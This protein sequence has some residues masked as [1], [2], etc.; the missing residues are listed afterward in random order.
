M[1]KAKKK[2]PKPTAKPFLVRPGARFT[3]FNDGLCCTDIHA[4]GPITR[5][6]ARDMRRIDPQS[7]ELNEELEELCLKPVDGHCYFQRDGLC[8]VHAE[9]GAAAKPAGCRRF[10]YGLLKTPVGGRIT[11]EHRCPCRTLGERPEID[12]VDAEASLKDRS[13]ILED[14]GEI[15]AKVDLAPHR[16]VSFEEYVEL[17]TELI[18]RLLAGERAEDVLGTDPLCELDEGSWSVYAAE[19]FDMR[20]GTA[21]GE[22]LVMFGDALLELSAGH[23]PPE[24]LRPWAGAFERAIARCTEQVDPETLYNDWIADEIW[25]FR[26]SEWGS[27]ETGRKEMATRLAVA[28]KVQAR[29]QAL[30]IRPDQAAAEA[31]MVVETATVSSEWPKAAEAISED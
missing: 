6:E 27:F 17:E 5:A 15:E 31:I 28:R 16:K 20:D 2:T 26:W 25:M 1:A 10:P 30:G 11:T 23:T 21:G 14:D 3:C 4:L 18:G 9:Y 12:L 7:V 19:F 22:A 13:G 24:R 29:F 8:H